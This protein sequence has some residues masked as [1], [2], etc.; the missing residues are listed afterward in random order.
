MKTIEM[1]QDDCDK[2]AYSIATFFYNQLTKKGSINFYYMW[3]EKAANIQNYKDELTIEEEDKDKKY[4][5]QFEDNSCIGFDNLDEFTDILIDYDLVVAF[6][7]EL[8]HFV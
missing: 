5:L 8:Q 1:K 6:G 2:L 4:F 3:L 7:A